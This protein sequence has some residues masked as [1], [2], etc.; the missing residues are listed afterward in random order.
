MDQAILVLTNQRVAYHELMHVEEM[1]L[2]AK[3][4]TEKE[5]GNEL[6]TVIKTIILFDTVYKKIYDMD[7][8]HEVDYNKFIDING[9]KIKLGRFANFYRE[10]ESELGKLYLALIS[11]ESIKFLKGKIQ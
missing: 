11:S 2:K 1:P 10:K 6:L 4:N 5:N 9:T 3:N 8:A 7:E